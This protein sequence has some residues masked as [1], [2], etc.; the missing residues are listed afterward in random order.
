MPFDKLVAFQD[1]VSSAISSAIASALA[2]LRVAPPGSL[3]P[4]AGSSAPTGWLICD[5]SAVS[6]TTYADLFTAIGT[7]YGA[8]DGSTTF[9]LPDLGGRVVA[10]KEATA[11][12]LTA[13]LAGFNGNTL[14]AA[15]GDQRVHSHNHGVNDPTH[16][17]SFLHGGST[18]AAFTGRAGDGDGSNNYFQATTASATGISIQNFGAGASQNVQPT[19]VLNYIIAT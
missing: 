16:S 12:R 6:R 8:G 14:G 1:W 4:Y 11:T 7:T 18:P 15:G 19:I 5:G 10:G 2:P 3:M 17:H 9:N 13:A